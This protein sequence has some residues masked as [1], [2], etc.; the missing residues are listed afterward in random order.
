MEPES[1]ARA[2]R[3]AEL[4]RSDDVELIVG[5]EGGWADDEGEQLAATCELVTMGSQILR[6][7]AVPLV[8]MTALRVAWNAA[9]CGVQSAES[10]ESAEC[11]VQSAEC[12][13]QSA[14]QL[15]ERGAR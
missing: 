3:I 10:A 11:R 4:P 12:R 14:L 5:P 13:V 8:A 6:A 1:A 2:R 15:A 7:D 9:Q